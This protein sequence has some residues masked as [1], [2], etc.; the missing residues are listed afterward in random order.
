MQHRGM[1]RAQGAGSRATA[2]VAGAAAIVLAFTLGV[3]PAVAA[4]AADFPSWADVQAAKRDE[5]SAKAQLTALLH[6]GFIQT[7][8]LAQLPR[9]PAYLDGILLRVR[10]L[11]EHPGRD[12][13]WQSE[14]ERATELYRRAGG[15]LPLAPDSPPALARVRWL[16]EELRLSLFAQTIPTSEPV[17]AQRIQRALS[18]LTVR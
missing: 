7:T 8:G 12:R 17:S 5:A 3:Q 11:P 9:F 16:L 14:A 13:V 6:P 18:E 4:P 2:I 15:T 10:K 1:N